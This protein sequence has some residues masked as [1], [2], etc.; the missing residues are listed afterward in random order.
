MVLGSEPACDLCLPYTGVAQRHARL[1]HDD[2][3]LTL[4]DLGGRRGVL[5][6]GKRVKRA[7]LDLLDEIRLGGVTLLVEDVAPEKPADPE[8]AA[9]EPTA[10]PECRIDPQRMLDHIARLSR[11]V[12]SDTESRTTSESLLAEVLKD[13]G[14]G[15]LFLLQASGSEVDQGAIKIV[16]TTEPQWLA[17][18]EELAEQVQAH[19]DPEGKLPSEGA[20][21][22]GRLN[23]GTAWLC[24]HAF[25]AVARPYVLI[26]AL[27]R[28]TPASWSA[29]SSFRTLGYLLGLGLVHHVGAYEPILPGVGGQGDLTLDPGLLLGPSEAMS[30]VLDQLRGAI[31]PA[32]HVLLRGETGVGKERLARTLHLSRA[33]FRRG[34]FVAASCAGTR[35]MQLEADL[36]GAEVEGKEGPVR[37]EGK[38]VL[39]D[40]GT[41]FLDDIDQM[42]LDLQARLVR[43]LRS[44]EVEP[45]GSRTARKVDVRLVAA[46]RAALEPLAARDQFRVDLAYRLSQLVVDVP[47][48]KERREDLPL[49]IQSHVNRFC[50]EAGRRI[51]G[52]TVKAM[53]AL[54]SYAYPGNLGELEN[55]VRHLVYRSP[56][57]RPIDRAD[58]PEEVRMAAVQGGN[59]VDAT[60]D[61]DLER[62]VAGV[63]VA[64]I[65]EALRRSQG[66]KT[67]A[68]RTL[69]LSRNG[70]AMKME[71]YGLKG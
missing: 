67:Q 2:G 34:P 52:I 45:A 55:I 28:F 25:E 37:R 53:T 23:G 26:V 35:P 62:L 12:L 48:L 51:Q 63:E 70:L 18:G 30:R 21:F 13:C 8:T 4:E 6:N 15:V 38:L 54:L 41:L 16:V 64:A 49:L 24:A 39:A 20:V 11:W 59:G 33:R 9:G 68:A 71:R 31:D 60:S 46:S 65:R 5:V 50:H 7:T 40:G 47:S 22:D 56:T 3:G 32:V 36:F 61:L 29:S 58:L 43:F 42:P 19:R 17:A 57:G 27:P 69:G 14:G 44:G 1:T 66:N 10:P